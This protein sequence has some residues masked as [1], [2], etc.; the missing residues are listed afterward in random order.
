MRL[1]VWSAAGIAVLAGVAIAAW[2]LAGLLGLESW[3][4]VFAA[5]LLGSALLMLVAVVTPDVLGVATGLWDATRTRA[6]DPEL[7]ERLRQLSIHDVRG[8]AVECESRAATL[9]AAGS[10]RDRKMASM[11]DV[12]GRIWRRLERSMRDAGAF[13]VA[14]LPEGDV[15]RWG[16]RLGLWRDG[17]SWDPLI[18]QEAAEARTREVRLPPPTATRGRM[19]LRRW[20]GPRGRRRHR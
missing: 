20:P 19:V 17:L 10:R 1:V 5:V 2:W 8:R 4:A 18:P 16:R 9:R 15:Q 7:L 11:Y 12:P 6:P 3:Q 13:H 14:D